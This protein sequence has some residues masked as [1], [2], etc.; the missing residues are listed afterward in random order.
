MFT[1]KSHWVFILGLLFCLRQPAAA[2]DGSDLAG[3]LLP[4]PAD[5]TNHGAGLAVLAD[6][7]LLACWFSGRSEAS[8]DARILCARS[9]DGG[10]HWAP[11]SVA[12][13]PGERAEGAEAPAKTVGNATLHRDADGRLWLI[14]NV[15]QRWDWPLIG[16]V[17][18]NWFCGRVD[19]KV[20]TDDGASWSPARRLDDHG[21]A[22]TRA[23][24]LAL[25]G[26]LVLLPF[27]LEGAET[28]FLDI[29]D[30]TAWSGE[31]PVS[32]P[33]D[34]P[35]LIQPSLV[36]QADGRV[37]AFLRDRRRGFV[38][39]ALF[40]S[41]ARRW[42]AAEPTDL[43]N[44]DSAVEVLPGQAG[45]FVLIHNPGTEDRRALALAWSVDGVRFHQG[46]DLV[47][48]DSQGE[49]AYPTAVR[50]AD[51]AFH[52]VYSSDGKRRIRHLRFTPAW[53]E[54]CLAPVSPPPDP[55]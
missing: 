30:L 44:P 18:R 7:A 42:S 55:G 11:P 35:G 41:A 38:Y 3:S 26:R 46:C 32:V 40:D 50:D 49:V 13:E 45:R 51:G 9:A 15:V 33:L 36:R 54:N 20:S 4:A 17:C 23:K 1:E 21:G 22:L 28:A 47:A 2:D 39:T 10:E 12:V 52:L 37:R 25:D 27:Y 8:A 34:A 5:A 53:L 43:A 29:A 16:N 31:P 6:G 14:Y 48:A 19:A 24:P